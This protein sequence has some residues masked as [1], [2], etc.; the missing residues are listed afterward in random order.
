LV[1]HDERGTT[2]EG[3]AVKE[4]A[5]KPDRGQRTVWLIHWSL[6]FF[7][8]LVC[9]LILMVIDPLVFAL[10]ALGWVLFMV[11]LGL[12]LPA[13]FR[14]L[15]YA[16]GNDAI[17]GQRGVFFKR[18]VIMPYHKI[19]NVDIT[20]GPLQR[21]FGVGYLHCQTA[22]AGGQQGGRAEL[23]M[24]GLRDL[25]QTREAIMERVAGAALAGVKAAG[26]PAAAGQADSRE[27][28]LAELKK[29]RE[30]LERRS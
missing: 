3:G 11:P 12:W 9:L 27:P 18:S 14:S 15:D 1:F 5:V 24:E 29:I 7:P 2:K 30:V 8:V 6:W 13:Y 17:K 4:I 22:G 28:I 21:K 26:S 23:K 19:T 16:I 25:E 20:H 10:C